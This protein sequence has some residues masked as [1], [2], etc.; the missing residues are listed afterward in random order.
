[1]SLRA[2]NIKSAI[3]AQEARRRRS[4]A[5]EAMAAAGRMPSC[6]DHSAIGCLNARRRSSTQRSLTASDRND[7]LQDDHVELIYQRASPLRAAQ[8]F[9][10]RSSSGL[11]GGRI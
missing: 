6:T 1:M 5:G 4:R 2:D 7:G 11:G 10:R 8:Q 3:R 9:L